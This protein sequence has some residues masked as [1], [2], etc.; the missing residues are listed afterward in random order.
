[1]AL[2][3]D[4]TEKLRSFYQLTDSLFTKDEFRQAV[5]NLTQFI[6][7]AVA[8]LEGRIDTRLAQL[9]DGKQGPKGDKGESITGPRGLK[10]DQGAKGDQGDPGVPGKDANPADVVALT[11]P[12]LIA[13]IDKRIPLLGDALRSVLESRVSEVT[14]QSLAG[15]GAGGGTSFS[16]S[17]L[18]TLKAQQPLSLNFK[19]SGAPTITPGQNGMLELDFPSSALSILA[20]TGTVNDSNKAFTFISKPN[21]IYVNGAGYRENH[22]W[23]WNAGTSTATLDSPVGNGGDI[24]GT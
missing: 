16:I 4:R 13:E 9:K 20:A 3:S 6:K 11:L 18:G 12:Q 19:G 5:G 17:E 2:L 1:M 21:I 15:Y 8:T 22:G 23:T 10:G 7:N 14:K 24:Y